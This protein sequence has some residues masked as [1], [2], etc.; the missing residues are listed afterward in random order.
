MVRYLVISPVKDEERHI[1]LTLES[2][3]V[4][5]HK[6]VRWIIVDDGSTDRTSE[7]VSYYSRQCKFVSLVTMP[8]GEARQPGAAVVRAF[9]RG[10]QTALGLEFDFVVKLDCDLSFEADYFERLLSKFVEYPK[11]GIASGV[12]LEAPDGVTW[13]EVRMPTYHAA[14]ASKVVRKTCFEQIDGF[15][16]CRGWDTVDEIRAMARGWNCRHFR[17]L[18]MRHWKCEGSGIGTLRTNF[19]HGEIYYRTGGT[20]LFLL[21]KVLH[22]FSCRPVI[23][24]GLSLLWGYLRTML[25]RQGR[26]V[27]SEE[28]RLY[29]TLLNRR[30]AQHVKELLKTN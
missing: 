11:L 17:E 13:R 14:G 20:K 8:P 12:Y 16:L 3:A 23:I 9:N 4:Q 22:R 2:M 30:M 24:G 27:T 28:A 7:I 6:P 25:S 5:R 18:K 1:K 19:M 21:I 10:Y 26:L 29:R 15:M